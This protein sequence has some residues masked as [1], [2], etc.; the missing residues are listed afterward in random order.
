[1]ANYRLVRIPS[2]DSPTDETLRRAFEHV[3]ETGDDFVIDVDQRTVA[4][5]ISPEAYA[6]L[7]RARDR[8]RRRRLLADLDR[9]ALESEGEPRVLS[10]KELEDVAVEIGKEINARITERLYLEAWRN[11]RNSAD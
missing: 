9:E 1:M 11:K 5:V 3:K 2:E 4:V 8:D 6:D 7:Q 10:D